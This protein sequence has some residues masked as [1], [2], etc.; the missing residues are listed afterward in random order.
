MAKKQIEYDMELRDDALKLTP[1][2]RRI[3]ENSTLER[4]DSKTIRLIRNTK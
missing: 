4:I 1:I 3:L 2:G